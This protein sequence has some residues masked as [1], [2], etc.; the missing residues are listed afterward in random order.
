MFYICD[1]S[2]AFVAATQRIGELDGSIQPLPLQKQAVSPFAKCRNSGLA[3]AR[4]GNDAR[5]KTRLRQ[6]NYPQGIMLNLRLM[7]VFFGQRLYLVRR[8]RHVIHGV[9][10]RFVVAGN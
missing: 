10:H 3:D 8:S 1:K 4:T 5:V 9:D 2:T 6:P 7:L